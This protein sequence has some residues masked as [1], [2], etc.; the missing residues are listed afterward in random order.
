MK[1]PA[2]L[3]TLVMLP[4]SHSSAWPLPA[5]IIQDKTRIDDSTRGNAGTGFYSK[6]RY[7]SPNYDERN[8]TGGVTPTGPSSGSG[9]PNSKGP[10]SGDPSSGGSSSP[11]GGAMTEGRPGDEDRKSV[12]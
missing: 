12:V 3:L 9:D 6:Y 10:S 2:L 7:K 8:S 5:Q 1:L 11:G 4:L